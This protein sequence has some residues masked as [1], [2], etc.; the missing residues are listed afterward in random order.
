MSLA[1]IKGRV[2][3]T[4]NNISRD[5]EVRLVL[6][7]RSGVKGKNGLNYQGLTRILDFI[8]S[9]CRVLSKGVT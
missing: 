9:H 2:S 7:F 4:E 5:S 3:E 6:G 8:Q 1:G